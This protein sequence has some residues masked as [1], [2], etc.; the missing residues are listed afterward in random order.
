[1]VMDAAASTGSSGGVTKWHKCPNGH[2][3]GVGDC[4]QLN[5]SGNCI[6]CG[7][8]IGGSDSH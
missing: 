7:A 6:E 4:G 8:T 1:M 5:G 3:Y 2:V